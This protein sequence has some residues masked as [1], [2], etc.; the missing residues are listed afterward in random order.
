[1][2]CF[3]TLL[4]FSVVA[5]SQNAKNPTP[6]SQQFEPQFQHDSSD[7]IKLALAAIRATR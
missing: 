2:R 7:A 5:I 3:M 1:M 6:Q 4:L